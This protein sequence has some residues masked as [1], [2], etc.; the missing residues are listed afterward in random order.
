MSSIIHDIK[1]QSTISLV[2]CLIT[3]EPLTLQGTLIIPSNLLHNIVKCSTLV[4]IHTIKLQAL[5]PSFS[6][7]SSASFSSSVGFSGFPS[8]VGRRK[9]C[10]ILKY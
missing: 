1:T 6:V 8:G 2:T 3:V 7:A 10:D 5:F 9:G 4:Y